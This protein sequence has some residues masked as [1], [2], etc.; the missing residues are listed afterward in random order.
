MG[1]ELRVADAWLTDVRGAWV[2][3]AEA[4]LAMARAT[5]AALVVDMLQGVS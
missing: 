2:T 4:P 5:T 3:K 1:E